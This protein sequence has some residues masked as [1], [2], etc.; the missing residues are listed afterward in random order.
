[1]TS[2]IICPCFSR[3]FNSDCLSSTFCVILLATVDSDFLVRPGSS[4]KTSLTITDARNFFLER[5]SSCWGFFSAKCSTQGSGDVSSWLWRETWSHLNRHVR[6]GRFRP[7][8]FCGR[9]SS[10]VFMHWFDQAYPLLQVLCGN[11]FY[12]LLNPWDWEI[13][14]C[15]KPCQPT[16]YCIWAGNKT[17]ACKHSQLLP[18]PGGRPEDD[19]Q[20]LLT[21]RRKDTTN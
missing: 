12:L 5:P 4:A 8:I 1:M 9:Y 18:G 19:T 10:A 11:R 16:N 13:V 2:L 14:N 17:S 3:L 15:E 21:I 6:K 20:H 7:L